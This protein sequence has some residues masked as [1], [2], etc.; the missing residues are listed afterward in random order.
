MLPSQELRD[1]A[2][3]VEIC[4]SGKKTPRGC[5]IRFRQFYWL[6]M[7]NPKG[8]LLSAFRLGSEL[9]AGKRLGM[10]VPEA[11][12]EVVDR[13]LKAE[14]SLEELERQY[15]AARGSKESYLAL[16]KKLKEL[17]GVGQMRVGSFLKTCAPKTKD[18]GRS[19]AR[20]VLVE[21]AACNRQVINHGAYAALRKSIEEF[22]AAH[23]THPSCKDLIKPLGNVGLKYCFDLS[24]KC[25]AYARQWTSRA[26]AS[27]KE[28]KCLT[29]L[30]KLLLEYRDEE[31]ASAK[32]KRRNM[33]PKQYGA[34][35]LTARLG[36]AK[37][38]LTGLD[39]SQTFGV[40]RPIHAQWRR[41]ASAGMQDR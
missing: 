2:S 21:A 5:D 11:L 19:W 32:E 6:M 22:V 23:P 8:E 4:L 15:V 29:A 27:K 34:L 30:A 36:R 7:F 25:E 14:P 26:T 20:G 10:S 1:L 33:K 41:E 35:R 37:E 3:R 13:G 17:A 24:A 28:K 38:T 16:R 39:R 31:I 18:P 9:S 40:M 12:V